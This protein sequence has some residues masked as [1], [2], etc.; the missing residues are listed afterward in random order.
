MRDV[1]VS[2]GICGVWF[3]SSLVINFAKLPNVCTLQ[4]IMKVGAFCV[5]LEADVSTGKHGHE[6]LFL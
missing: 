5:E 2:C 4:I 1:A 6:V 3:T